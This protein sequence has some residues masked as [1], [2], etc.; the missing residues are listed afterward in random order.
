MTIHTVLAHAGAAAKH[1]WPAAL[2][3]D[4]PIAAAALSIPWW[5]QPAEA[6]GQ[7]LIVGGG[8]VLIV[9]RIL[10]ASRRLRGAQEPGD[11]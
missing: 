1:F 2:S 5:L 11:E 7:A 6:W 9:M 4:T 10:I 3:V 8:V